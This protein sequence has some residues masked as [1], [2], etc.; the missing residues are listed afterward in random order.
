MKKRLVCICLMLCVF[1]TGC[2][3]QRNNTTAEN[4]RRVVVILKAMDS[5]HW[6]EVAD[7]LRQAANDKNI[8]LTILYPKQESDAD[9]Q[10]DMIQ[11]AIDSA[12]DALAV[13]PCD[14]VAAQ[15]YMVHAR[16]QGIKT[17]YLDE[18]INAPI[19]MPY[20]GSDNTLVGEIAAETLRTQ[21]P[22]KSGAKIAVIAGNKEQTTHNRRVEGF[23]KYISNHT[24]FEVVDVCRVDNSS[25]AGAQREMK[26]V[27]ETYPD[28]DAVFCTNAMMTIGALQQK[29][30]NHWDNLRLVGVDTQSDALTAVQDGDI[31]AMISQNGYDIGYRTIE[32]LVD[33]MN[34]ETVAERTY[35]ENRVII[36]TNVK[37][38]LSEYYKEGRK[39]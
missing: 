38:F 25:S 32:T 1:L 6:M 27:M 24:D 31:L 19:G 35:V 33:A 5:I 4:R 15:E 7:G 2:M 16:E 23:E 21:M 22:T 8:S 14:A 34:G 17:V 26:R 28:L 9:T 37:S 11:D 20:I 10:L 13:A 39:T 36:Q 30:R 29:K 3:P 18:E 12:P